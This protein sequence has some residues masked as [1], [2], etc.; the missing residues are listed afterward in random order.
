MIIAFLFLPFEHERLFQNHL[1]VNRSSMKIPYRNNNL[2]NGFNTFKALLIIFNSS[3]D[4]KVYMVDPFI[5]ILCHV[6]ASHWTFNESQLAGF[7]MM[8]VFTERCLFI[9]T[10][11]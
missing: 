11:H 7:S 1:F 9:I 3:G 6:E 4:F 10:S 8:Q 5:G 2:N